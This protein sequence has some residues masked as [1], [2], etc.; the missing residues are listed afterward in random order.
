MALD[1]SGLTGV[2]TSDSPQNTKESD[3]QLGQ[4][5][6]LKLMLAQLKNQDPLKPQDPSAFLTQLAQ[7]SQVTG[8]ENMNKAVGSLSDSLM[9]SQVL[10]GTSMVGR[11]VLANG[12]TAQLTEG[13][14]ISG[15]VD[16]PKVATAVKVRVLDGTGQLVREFPL[17]PEEGLMEFTWDGRTNSGA[18]APGGPYEFEI[19]ASAGEL[20]GSLDPMIA[21]RVGSVTIDPS[22]HE[23][24]LNTNN[25]PFA[26]SDVRR[27][28]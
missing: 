13:G 23:L 4:N 7:F 10:S 25:G 18:A 2:R 28:Q 20:N 27:I 6:F 26:L 17:E 3:G 5:E 16:I 11:D 19:I 24:T 1:L 9:S 21:S 12:A 22:T 14:T 8:I 15:A